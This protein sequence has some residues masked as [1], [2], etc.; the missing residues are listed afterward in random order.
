MIE[1]RCE[2]QGAR[3]GH[4]KG[5][6]KTNIKHNISQK[7]YGKSSVGSVR[8]DLRFKVRGCEQ[9]PALN[10]TDVDQRSGEYI[11]P[12]NSQ[13]STINTALRSTPTLNW[14]L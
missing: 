1:E 3:L 8:S 11:S 10:I 2:A 12:V 6:D 9:W 7:L 4:H 5:H 14:L 13:Q